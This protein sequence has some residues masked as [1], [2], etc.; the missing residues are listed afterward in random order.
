MLAAIGTRPFCA[1]AVC[2]Q[3]PLFICLASTPVCGCGN[4]ITQCAL[5][6]VC[7]WACMWQLSTEMPCKNENALSLPKGGAVAL[8]RLGFMSHCGYVVWGWHALSGLVLCT[9][10][11]CTCWALAVCMCH[12]TVHTSALLLGRCQ[13]VNTNCVER[14]RLQFRMSDAALW[15]AGLTLC[16]VGGNASFCCPRHVL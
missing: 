4:V 6:V 11:F 8:E 14:Q 1:E 16:L 9:E 2:A 10:H 7:G 5:P 15:S 13:A 12:T 3:H